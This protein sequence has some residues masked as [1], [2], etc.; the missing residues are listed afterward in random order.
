MVNK[1][2]CFQKKLSRLEVNCDCIYGS[3]FSGME[4][5]IEIMGW[6][7]AVL[8]RIKA[9]HTIPIAGSQKVPLGGILDV[10][11]GRTVLHCRTLV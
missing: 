4:A 10:R 8:N 9:Y 3:Y 5:P 6:S 7:I 1:I 11:D 2:V